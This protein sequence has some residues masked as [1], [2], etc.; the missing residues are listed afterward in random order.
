MKDGG[1]GQ[2]RDLPGHVANN[3]GT[4][5]PP[6]FGYKDRLFCLRKVNILCNWFVTNRR[7]ANKHPVSEFDS[8]RLVW[9]MF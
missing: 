2:F 5:F 3:R 7:C 4:A 1:L 6:Q 8:G 9:S